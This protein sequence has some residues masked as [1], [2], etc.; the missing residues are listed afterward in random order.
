MVSCGISP[1]RTPSPGWLSRYPKDSATGAFLG[2]HIP[3]FPGGLVS[4]SLG[5]C[6]S[7]ILLFA[8][9]MQP[10][11]PSVPALLPHPD[12]ALEHWPSQMASSGPC[13]RVLADVIRGTDTE[14][15][16]VCYS[17]D[18]GQGSSEGWKGKLGLRPLDL[19]GLKPIPVVT[20]SSWTQLQLSV[21]IANAWDRRGFTFWMFLGFRICGHTQW[22]I[23]E[24]EPKSEHEIYVLTHIIY[25]LSNLI[26]YC[27]FSM[28]VF[29]LGSPKFKVRCGMSSCGFISVFKKFQILE[30]SD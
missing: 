22:Y 5:L 17:P 25:S 16:C 3:S 18:E 1:S 9:L 13:S 27:I 29:S 23:L 26:Q 15:Q 7:L 24:M 11:P 6:S 8:W 12:A 10:Q 21:L 30:F 14:S 4:L 2:Q 20:P 19:G 28:P